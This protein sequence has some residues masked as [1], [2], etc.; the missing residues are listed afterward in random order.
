MYIRF[1]SP[2]MLIL[3]LLA[4]CGGTIEVGI[5]RTTTPA[6]AATPSEPRTAEPA[7]TRP[8]VHPTASP[9]ATP[10]PPDLSTLEPTRT[11][12]PVEPTASPTSTPSPDPSSFLDVERE[13]G[14]LG[15]VWNLADLRYGLHPD[16]VQI[17]WEMGESRDHGPYF[18]V[19]E[20]DN[21]A[22]PFPTG[23]DPS[24]G[25]ARIDLVVSDL[26]ARNAPA[27]EQLPLT[28]PDD[29]LVTRIGA[30]PTF[31]DAHLGFSIGLSEPAAYEVIELTE[32]VRI[33]IAVRYPAGLTDEP[34]PTPVAAALAL[35]CTCTHSWFFPD[36][37]AECAGQPPQ[38]SPT[39]AQHFERGL[40]LWREQPDVYGSQIHVFFDDGEWPSWNPTNDAWRAGLPESD[41]GIVPPPGYYQPVRGFG[42]VWREAFF[43]T[44][45]LSARDRLG[46][47]M[48]AETALGELHMQCHA[49]DRYLPHCY[50]AGPDDVV[51][52]TGPGNRWFV[53]QGPTAVPTPS[54]SPPITVP[55]S[56]DCAS[57]ACVETE[58]PQLIEARL[59]ETA[60]GPELNVI[61]SGGYLC[62]AGMC[63]LRVDE[64]PKSFDLTFD[65]APAGLLACHLDHCEGTLD[66]PAAALLGTHTISV[67]GGSSI[68]VHVTGR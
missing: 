11:P 52:A 61:G 41:P 45:G 18:T 34:Q 31:S 4:A 59:V 19:V 13:G 10:V 67:E 15:D 16:R 37:P 20:A 62:S 48:E 22:S 2:L 40:M 43:G 58:P 56:L 49:N 36:P 26:Y 55:E 27:L 30:Y 47:A 60:S 5:E 12:T 57:Q 33:V 29:P 1:I 51:Y 64:S 50:L 38:V 63:G 24:W 23:P 66:L 68:T 21:A 3:P 42:K 44:I 46:W 28:L 7:R 65:E 32:P 35:T 8:P 54:T 53:W 39:V 9:T 14:V 6:Q 25:E 17:V